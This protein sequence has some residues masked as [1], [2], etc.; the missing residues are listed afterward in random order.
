[1]L[2]WPAY[3]RSQVKCNPSIIIITTNIITII[4]IISSSSSSSAS[5]PCILL[6]QNAQRPHELKIEG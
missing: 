1:M 2:L 3:V 5:V 6:W 4:I